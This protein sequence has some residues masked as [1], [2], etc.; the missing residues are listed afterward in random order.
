MY[1]SPIMLLF[2][3]GGNLVGSISSNP[4]SSNFLIK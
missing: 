3:V 1:T 4:T 2:H